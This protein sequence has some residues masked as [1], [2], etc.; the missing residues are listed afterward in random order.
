MAEYT[1]CFVTLD[2]TILSEATTITINHDP[3]LVEVETLAGGLKGMAEGSKRMTVTI[4][5]AVPSADFEIDPTRYMVAGTR[6]DFGAVAAGR[7]LQQSMWITSSSFTRGV[8]QEPRVSI[9][10]TGPFK[11]W[12]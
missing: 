4:D 1:N 10:L 6:V 9:S 12:E 3:R 11:E 7:Q 8:N 5:N 2:N